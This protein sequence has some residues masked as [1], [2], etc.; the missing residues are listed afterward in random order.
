MVSGNTDLS[1]KL[2]AA[3]FDLYSFISVLMRG[4][5]EASDVLQETN[6]EIIRHGASYDAGL[7]FMPWAR[8][9]ARKCILRFYS[10]RSR[11]K[12]VFD[13]ELFENIARR[14]PCAADERPLDD[15]ARLRR[16]MAKLLPKH[17][18]II[19]ARYMREEAVKDIAA[20][21][22]RSEGAVSMLLHRIRQLLAECIIRE[23]KKAGEC[24]S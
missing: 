16:C 21:E 6:L 13:S 17:R 20:R 1:G 7:P 9:V 18:E 24:F 15:L 19:V 11:E 12:L 14:V 22:R 23:R 10:R 4:A 2:A 8:G 3:Q 5:D